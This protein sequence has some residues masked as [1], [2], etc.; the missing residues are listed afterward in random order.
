VGEITDARVGDSFE[1]PLLAEIQSQ[2][3]VPAAEGRNCRVVQRVRS[4]VDQYL[5]T[6]RFST[7]VAT[8]TR[9]GFFWLTRKTA[10]VPTLRTH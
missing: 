5:Q 9:L 1:N 7:D 4:L 2:E 8:L 6:G 3:V 10:F